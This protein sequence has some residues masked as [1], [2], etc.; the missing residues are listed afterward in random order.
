MYICPYV[1]MYSP[2]YAGTYVATHVF[3]CVSVNC[4]WQDKEIKIIILGNKN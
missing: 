2:I 1:R 3:M 4:K